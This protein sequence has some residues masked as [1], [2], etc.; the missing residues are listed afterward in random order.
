M[1]QWPLWCV[2]GR[3]CVP[4]A[5]RCARLRG[6]PAARAQGARPP[7]RRG[8]RLRLTI[9]GPPRAAPWP[10]G[11]AAA[12][13]LP[14]RWLPRV[15]ARALRPRPAQSVALLV[16]FVLLL[17]LSCL[18]GR[19]VG[20]ARPP[21]PRSAP[22]AFAVAHAAVP[23]AAGAACGRVA[24]HRRGHSVCQLCRAH[25]GFNSGLGWGGARMRTRP[26]QRIDGSAASAPA[27]AEAEGMQGMSG[28]RPPGTARSR[29]L[30]RRASMRRAA[31]TKHRTPRIAHRPGGR[32]P[33]GRPA[34]RSLQ[35]LGA[36]GV[37]A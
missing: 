23:G 30:I 24:A 19:P 6:R 12:A 16:L 15:R 22:A 9:F 29:K 36:G 4:V 5:A 13:L 26:P 28:V 10:P 11:A 31:A 35:G 20:L 27:A 21:A 7:H 8:G 32:R 2:S 37:R 17:L 34:S 14:A 33:P 25:G 18:R 3:A 1:Q